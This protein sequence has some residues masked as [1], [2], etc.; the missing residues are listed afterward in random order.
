[1][2][3]LVIVENAEVLGIIGLEWGDC[4]REVCINGFGGSPCVWS[5]FGGKPMN[6]CDI[7]GGGRP[8]GNPV[9]AKPGVGNAVDGPKL[10][11]KLLMARKSAS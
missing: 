9:C 3:V 4:P 7:P 5:R 11:D 2:V 6:P 10:C 1:M 8:C